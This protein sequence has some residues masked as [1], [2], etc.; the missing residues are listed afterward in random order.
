MEFAVHAPADGIVEDVHCAE[1]RIIQAGDAL[2]VI[3]SDA[4]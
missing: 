1:G 4:A 2:I 3:R